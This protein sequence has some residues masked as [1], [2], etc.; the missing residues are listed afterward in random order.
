MGLPRLRQDQVRT[1]LPGPKVICLAMG[2][3]WG[4]TTL[5]GVYS[6]KSA[7]R[8][9][10][11]GWIVPTYRN[12]RPLWRFCEQH[13]A[14][15][16]GRLRVNRSELTI[17]WPEGGRIAIYSADN[18]TA[19]RGES[20]D[21]VIV[22]EAAMIR[23]ETYTDV[24][25]PTLADRNGR[26][27]LISTP[28][29]LNWFYNEFQRG[30]S[31]GKLQASFH[32]PTSANPLPNIQRAYL[33]AKDRVSERTFRQEWEAEFL[34]ADGVVFRNIDTLAVLAPQDKPIV[35]HTYVGGI[36]W[37][38]TNDA[39][40][41]TVIDAT[42]GEVAATDRMVQT[43][44]DLQ[45]T[46][47]RAMHERFHVEAWI[48]EYNSIGGP[49]VESLQRQ[50]IPVRPFTTTNAT[51][52]QIIDALALAFEQQILKLLRNPVLTGELKAYQSK[53]LAS[54]LMTY[55]APESMHDD[56]VMSLALAWYGAHRRGV[57]LR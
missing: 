10:A 25:M 3:R 48:G 49:Q 39:T 33:L 1:I 28:K 30:L 45:L 17:E 36:D 16:A 44:F 42:A 55:S 29:G 4:K 57:L 12:A 53:A 23:A 2:R 21:L 43:N 18:D 13:L 31:D 50:G 38:R 20:F 22:D 7:E 8:G 41:F 47:L 26:C 56:H 32:A 15:V 37:G 52:A 14:L 40:V 51:K 54:G 11:V 46:R 9:R 5:G 34:E 35:G 6:I 27:L 19:I 24:I